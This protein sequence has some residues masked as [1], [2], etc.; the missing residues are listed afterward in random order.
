[1]DVT[2]AYLKTPRKAAFP[3][4]RV[5]GCGSGAGRAARVRRGAVRVRWYQPGG[6]CPGGGIL[7]RNTVQSINYYFV[8]IATR[9]HGGDFSEIK[10]VYVIAIYTR[11]HNAKYAIYVMVFHIFEML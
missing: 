11:V 1:M 10:I 3:G 6:V 2:G 9:F 5:R 8:A 7:S 4:L